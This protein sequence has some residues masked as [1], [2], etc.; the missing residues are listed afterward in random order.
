MT[1]ICLC[2]KTATREQ[3]SKDNNL[4]QVCE[5]N[6]RDPTVIYIPGQDI[7]VGEDLAASVNNQIYENTD[8]SFLTSDS[9]REYTNCQLTNDPFLTEGNQ[10]GR[11]SSVEKLFCNCKSPQISGTYCSNCGDEATFGSFFTKGENKFLDSHFQEGS[12]IGVDDQLLG[13]IK[14]RPKGGNRLFN[15]SGSSDNS[16]IYAKISLS[17]Q[18]I[19]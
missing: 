7:N 9:E 6:Y 5:K 13:S 17:G 12:G 11:E 4:C 15:L 3:I 16:P 8:T 14:F 19:E 10:D 2:D 18:D 1:D